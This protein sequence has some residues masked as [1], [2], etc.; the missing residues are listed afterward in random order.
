[1]RRRLFY[2][3]LLFCVLLPL[4]GR[5]AE[6]GLTP[7]DMD[8]ILKE[9]LQ[10]VD[11]VD[12]EQYLS[13]LQQEYEGFL[14]DLSI[15]GVLAMLRGQDGGFSISRLF[16]A[17]LTM[18]F[19]E[20]LGQWAL[21]VRLIVLSV[22]CVILQHLHDALEGRVANVA[23]M[24]CHLVLI[25]FALQSFGMAMAVTRQALQ[26]M[27]NFVHA[28]YP[29]LLTILLS[30]GNVSSAALFHP[31]LTMA[32]SA[33]TTVVGGT[34]VP[35]IF[36]AGILVMVNNLA[37]QVQVSRLAY[38]LRDIG[39]GIMGV[40]FMMFVGLTI[41]QGTAGAVVDGVAFRAGKFAVKAFLPVVGSLIADSFE[42]VAG[43]SLL[44]K[45]AIGLIG[46]LGVVL[47]CALPAI[48]IV[49]MIAVYRLAG[50]IIEPL[51]RTP[52]VNVLNNIAG[53]LMYFFGA[54]SLVGVMLFVL[55]T[56]VVSTG[57]SALMLR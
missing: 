34:V 9:Q 49:A 55:I 47:F 40:L 19:R 20:L 10:S 16:R 43:C 11:T 18:G 27:V 5:A 52:L 24:I 37:E 1:M 45:N 14:P 51:G 17:I 25:G 33:V 31:I 46:V 36:F 15:Q 23:Y 32:L 57:N 4:S 38:L 13:Q 39:T 12:L 42:T 54:L 35:L 8:Q 22:L 30:I 41:A 56:V 29:V 6:P 3:V 28:L 26:T 21:L 7:P 44:M 50:A 53:M 2:L 48:K